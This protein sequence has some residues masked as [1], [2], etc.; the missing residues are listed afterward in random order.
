MT[1]KKT[2][3]KTETKEQELKTVHDV[4][5]YIQTNLKAPKNQYNKFG[6]YNYR[7]KE[8]ILE[9]VKP[10][11]PF[12]ANLNVTDEVVLIG[13]RYYIKS[14]STLSFN[15]ETISSNGFAREDESKKG[16]DLSQLSGS[17]SS[18]AGKYSLNNLFCIDDTKDADHDSQ[19]EDAQ[20]AKNNTTQKAKNNTTQKAEK[21]A[22]EPE[23][24]NEDEE[25]EL[26]NLIINCDTE[27]QL[28]EIKAK[29]TAAKPRMTT[30][31][32]KTL[33]GMITKQENQICFGDNLDKAD[34]A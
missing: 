12:G 25:I 18:Y 10:L 5:W 11:L 31:Q 2:T 3:K 19:H 28:K 33:G 21:S 15:G 17:T 20:K 30:D 22:P 29:L 9:A 23:G 1:T 16:M 7:N 6:K 24:L 27:D 13:T 8:D 26:T 14:T 32:L 34:A 4:L